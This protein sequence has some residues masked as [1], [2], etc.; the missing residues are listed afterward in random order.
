MKVHSLVSIALAVALCSCGYDPRLELEAEVAAEKERMLQAQAE[1]EARAAEAQAAAAAAAR[2]TPERQ[3]DP[4]DGMVLIPAGSLR[5]GLSHE[6]Y[7]IDIHEVTNAQ[8][9]E[10]VEA[11][12]HV[13][14]AQKIGN[15]VV[16]V[17]V[18]PE[19]S[20]ADPE[21]DVAAAAHNL[22]ALVDGADWRHPE[23]PSSDLEG[24]WQHPVTQVSY[25]DAWAYARWAGK[26]L[27]RE[28]EWEFAAR[29]GLKDQPLPWGDTLEPEGRV[30]A[31]YWQGTFPHDNILADGWLRTAPVMSFPANGY[32]VHDTAGNVWEWAGA[33]PET[34]TGDWNPQGIAVR[35]TRGGS[36]LC[37]GRST[38]GY[39]I[40]E[41]YYV[42]S[43]QMKPLDDGNT[44]V[45]F[46]CAMDAE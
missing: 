28:V 20:P 11:T 33:P 9:A 42:T 22:W 32:G 2:A 21:G 19:A 31:N 35:P 17:G 30:L 6:A 25:L 46:R 10:F 29:G 7:W 40:C 15:A 14:D 1:A 37:A 36:F 24:R 34:V 45:G 13:T 23:G 27:P 3:G 38:P 26:R 43:R 41:G 4:T 12:G 5:A 39:H 16:F 18:D 8:F 44:N